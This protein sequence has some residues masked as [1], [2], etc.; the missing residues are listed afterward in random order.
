MIIYTKYEIKGFI[1]FHFSTVI[2]SYERKIT[3]TA[4]TGLF[5]FS[6][7]GEGVLGY[8]R[9]KEREREREGGLRTR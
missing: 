1:T 9:E 5:R 8:E 7:L 3:L 6:L 2:F 4:K